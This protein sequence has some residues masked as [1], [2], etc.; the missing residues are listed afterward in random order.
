MS[1]RPVNRLIISQPT[2]EG[3]EFTCAVRSADQD[4]LYRPRLISV[5]IG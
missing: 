5:R 2:I 4:A 1:I 3:L